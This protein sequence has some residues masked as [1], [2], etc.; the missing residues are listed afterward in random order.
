MVKNYSKQDNQE[1]LGFGK[2][3]CFRE[4]CQLDIKSW[5]PKERMDL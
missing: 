5:F 4:A 1:L 2:S 3:V